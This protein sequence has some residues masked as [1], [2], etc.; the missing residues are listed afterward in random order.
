MKFTVFLV[1]LD[2]LSLMLFR[3]VPTD[4]TACGRAK[5]S[6]VP[7]VVARNTTHDGSFEATLR[8]RRRCTE[9]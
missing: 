4:H 9:H 6:M 5:H 2:P 8:V 3:L 1:L 7:C